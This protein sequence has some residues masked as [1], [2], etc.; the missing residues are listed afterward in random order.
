[1]SEFGLALKRIDLLKSSLKA[2]DDS[3][4]HFSLEVSIPSQFMV[5][6][7]LKIDTEVAIGIFLASCS[8][9]WL[10]DTPSLTYNRAV[11]GVPCGGI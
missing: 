8:V 7:Y 5:A 11:L 2:P 6:I 1:M 9:R 4:L 10:P 3:M